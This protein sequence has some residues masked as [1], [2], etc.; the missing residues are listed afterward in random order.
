MKNRYRVI[1]PSDAKA[2]LRD[3]IEYIKKRS[4]LAAEKVRKGLLKKVK[5]LA[6]FPERFSKEEYLSGK[7]GNYRSVS[8]WHYKII[9]KIE[10][11]RV[12]ILRFMHTSRSPE[13]IKKL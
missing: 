13:E 10:V 9:Y 3:I 8:V 12:V 2:S 6:D 7:D 1:M 11:D 4:P 5:G